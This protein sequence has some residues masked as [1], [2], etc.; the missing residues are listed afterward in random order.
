MPTPTP[1]A[2]DFIKPVGLTVPGMVLSASAPTLVVDTQGYGSAQFVMSYG[3]ASNLDASNLVKIVPQ[4]AT[5]LGEGYFS[6]ATA[7]GLVEG[8]TRPI[9]SM[10]TGTKM[11][12]FEMTGGGRYKR[13]L[14]DAEGSPS[15]EVSVHVNLFNPNAP[16]AGS[17]EIGISL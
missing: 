11:K 14:F 13:V 2:S 17:A 10:F 15:I 9:D 12:S 5:A 6:A 8:D 7:A 4:T 1:K 16:S 3:S